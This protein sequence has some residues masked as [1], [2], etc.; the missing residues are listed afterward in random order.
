MIRY[1]DFNDTYLSKEPLHPSDLIGAALSVGDYVGA[2]GTDLITAVAI[3]Y[4]AS[5]TFCDGRSLRKRAGSRELP[6]HR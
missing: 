4:E 2:W 6:R 3:G 5:V 1:H